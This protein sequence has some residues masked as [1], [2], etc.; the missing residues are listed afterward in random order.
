MRIR[1]SGLS[2][3]EK[4]IVAGANATAKHGGRSRGLSAGWSFE[5]SLPGSLPDRLGERSTGCA[6]S[7]SSWLQMKRAGDRGFSIGTPTFGEAR[8]S[9]KAFQL[10]NVDPNG[11]TPFAAERRC[12]AGV[13][14]ALRDAGPLA[15][16]MPITGDKDKNE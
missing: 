13:R 10:T 1:N 5:W 6:P 3:F 15:K 9:N 11:L 8:P 4:R 7:K 14:S 12:W 2:G 16:A